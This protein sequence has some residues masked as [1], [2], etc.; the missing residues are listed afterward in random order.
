EQLLRRCKI[1]FTKY[2][3]QD[4]T[5]NFRAGSVWR[6]Y[7]D[8]VLPNKQFTWRYLELPLYS[9]RL[10]VKESGLWDGDKPSRTG[11][12][13]SYSNTDLQSVEVLQALATTCG[14]K[15]RLHL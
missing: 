7:V 10:L 2:T 9:K 3:L 6:A 14:Y 5:V 12:S 11:N 15:A 4:G 13:F 8:E 1:E